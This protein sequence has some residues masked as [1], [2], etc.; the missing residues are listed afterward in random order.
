MP[1]YQILREGLY[2]QVT[3]KIF[4]VNKFIDVDKVWKAT[5]VDSEF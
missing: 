2:N 3:D 5:K 4:V 1:P